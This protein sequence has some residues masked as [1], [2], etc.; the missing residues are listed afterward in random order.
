MTPRDKRSITYHLG[1]HASFTCGETGRTIP[2][3][4][5]A[6]AEEIVAALE[7]GGVPSSRLVE[8]CDECGEPTTVEVA[9]E[10]AATGRATYWPA[11]TAANGAR[12]HIECLMRKGYVSIDGKTGPDF[13]DTLDRAARVAA[14]PS[15]RTQSPVGVICR[16]PRCTCPRAQ[17]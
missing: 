10:R 6:T 1:K 17:P 15:N 2:L 9:K 16:V 8:V 3:P 13:V 5:T 14:C 11:V 4:E 12:G 7:A